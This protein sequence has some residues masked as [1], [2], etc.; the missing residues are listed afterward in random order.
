M[1]KYSLVKR[2]YCFMDKIDFD[3]TYFNPKDV[4]ECGQIFRFEPFKK[5]YKVFSTDKACY[6][7]I[8]GNSTVVESEYPDYFY[9]FFDLGREYAQVIE[10]IKV[11]GY[12]VITRA[13]EV[14][15]GLRL[16][17][18]DPEEMIFS[19]IISQNNNIPRIKGIISRIS[20]TVGERRE[21]M[22]EEYY[23]FPTAARLAERDAEFYKSLGAGYRDRF[24]V[25]T[26]KRIAAEGI[27]RLKTLDAPSLKK[28]LLTYNGIGP[29]VADCV[30]LFGFGRAAS[31]PVDTW[32]EKI[33]REDFGGSL[34]SRDKINAY[35]TSLFGEYSGFVQ[36]YLFY[37]K[38]ENL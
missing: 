22:G 17:N 6:V 20:R 2:L 3:K 8:D 31:F 14:A 32:V 16:L 37:C 11:F 18:Q 1:I 34:K 27:E 24:I 30:S 12:P 29:K 28:E 15:K 4:L 9:N 36:Q 35:F 38:R 33:Y 23:T 25:D 13:C 19:F 5:G 10:K 7:Y 21:F 26:A